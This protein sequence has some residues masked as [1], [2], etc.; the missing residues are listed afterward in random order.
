[1]GG[2]R[3][4][5]K[6]TLRAGSLAVT[7]AFAIAAVPQSGI[8]TV[9]V[10]V[11]D[12]DGLPVPG[13]TVE[14]F[15]VKEDGR[16]RKLYRVEPSTEPMHIALLIDDGGKSLGA[17][18]QAA[19]QFVERLQ[20]KA[21][22]SLTTTGGVPQKRVEF[23]QD[24]RIIYAALQQTFAN[25]APTTQLLNAVVQSARDFVRR[26]A[27]RPVIVAIVNE[28]EELSNVRAD[29]VLRSV[30]QSGAVFYYIGLGVPWTSGTLPSLESNRA[31]DSSAYESLQRNIVI[32]SAPKNSGGRS[33]QV[34][35]PAGIEPLM[36][37][38]AAEL[39]AQYTLTYQSD[40]NRARLEVET[41]RQGVRVRAP[42]RVGDR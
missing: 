4:Q 17:T 20:G 33:E 23:T 5:L 37:Q 14:D 2:D 16:A 27:A 32:G 24:P 35:L 34:L 9:Y 25:V 38:F 41:S 15:T 10:T 3:N 22:F 12:R 29:E 18:R 26:R 21:K 19:G 36:L 31:A 28:G 6:A 42:A 8:R 40:V 39:S 11:V 1:V 30:Q 13:L 7:C